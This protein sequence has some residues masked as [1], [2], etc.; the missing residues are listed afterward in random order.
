[1][2]GR[3]ITLFRM[4]GFAV[5]ADASWIIIVV[6]V[7]WSLAT[8]VF[9]QLHQGL[10]STQYW[11]MGLTGTLV[12][13]L[14]VVVHELAHSV[15]ARRFGIPMKGITLFVFGGVAEMDEE[16]PSPKAELLMALAGPV[17]SAAIA[18]LFITV[19]VTGLILRWPTMVVAVIQ[20]VGFT[21]ILLAAFNMLPAFP[22]D[23]GRVLRSIVWWRKQNVRVAT[24]IASQ[25]GSA[26]GFA[27]ILLGFYALFTG[28]ALGGVWWV[29]IGMFVRNAAAAAYQQVVIREALQGQPVSRFMNSEP[30]TVPRSVSVAELVQDYIYRYHY[31]MFPVVDG[32]KLVGCVTTR[33]VKQVPRE[34]WERQTVGSIVQKCDARNTVS[35]SADAMQALAKMGKSGLSR[36]MVAEGERL[37]GVIALKDMMRY[38]ALKMELEDDEAVP[39]PPS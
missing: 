24:R 26:L 20:Y 8:G 12:L 25:T 36:L 27:L 1:M 31:K 10:T 4:M 39:A 38:L 19:A 16:P 37:V 18:A 23:G 29:L 14:S 33:E 34:E 17:T 30:V 13:F 3:R 15:V 32:E 6:L 22:L 9:P 5:R 2:F 11:M 35:P 28:N 7:T 21:N